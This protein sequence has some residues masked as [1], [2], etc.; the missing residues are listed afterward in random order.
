M[1]TVTNL[2]NA[3][4]SGSLSV[5]GIGDGAEVGAGY[6]WLEGTVDGAGEGTGNGT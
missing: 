2:A 1:V 5:E 6:G 4:V 3:Q